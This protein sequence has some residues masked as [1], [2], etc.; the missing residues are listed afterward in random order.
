MRVAAALSTLGLATAVVAG[1]GSS[2][3]TTTVTSPA[4]ASPAPSTVA[5]VPASAATT[6]TATAAG[7]DDESSAGVQP[8]TLAGRLTAA[9]TV[10]AGPHLARRHGQLRGAEYIGADVAHPGW[11]TVLVTYTA[12][13]RGR[14]R[15]DISG[16]LLLELAHGRAGW[17]VMR[18]R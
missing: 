8:R 5:T 3:T 11:Q 15:G 9:A 1:C 16:D 2:T 7:P 18:A 4:V 17:T 14:G 6:T 12:R 13:G 10:Y